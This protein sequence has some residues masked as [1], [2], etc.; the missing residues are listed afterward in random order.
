MRDSKIATRCHVDKTWQQ[1]RVD[2]NGCA[3]V[4]TTE[5]TPE[6]APT[7]ALASTLH[8]LADAMI[9]ADLEALHRPLF[10]TRRPFSAP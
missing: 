9:R 8:K 1:H 5:D 2:R 10:S 6:V 7:P 4:T 3:A